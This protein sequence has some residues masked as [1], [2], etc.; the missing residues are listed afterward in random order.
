METVIDATRLIPGAIT[1]RILCDMG[2]NIIKLEDTE[3]GDYMDDL[4]PGA[5]DFLNH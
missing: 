4:S 2:Y 1:T 3:R 5:S